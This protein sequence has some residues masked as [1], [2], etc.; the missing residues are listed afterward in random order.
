MS[1]RKKDYLN[2]I[3]NY[4]LED[5]LIEIRE[6]GNYIHFPF[7]KGADKYYPLGNS[8]L[9]TNFYTCP[10]S[11]FEYCRDM[12]GLT[13]DEIYDMWEK[14]RT[15]IRNRV[16]NRNINESVGNR[17]EQIINSISQYMLEDTPVE[18]NQHTEK[19]IIDY[20]F[21]EFGEYTNYRFEEVLPILLKRGYDMDMVNYLQKTYSIKDWNLIV[22]ISHRYY[23][24]LYYKVKEI[25]PPPYLSINESMDRKSNYLDKI[26][27]YMIEDTKWEITMER[28]NYE[29]YVQV[30]IIWPGGGDSIFGIEQMG[31]YWD[32]YYWDLSD[33][34]YLENNFGINDIVLIQELYNRYINELRHIIYKEMKDFEYSHKNSINE[35]TYIGDNKRFHDYII[36]NITNNTTLRDHHF[37]LFDCNISIHLNH[38][39][40]NP[41]FEWVPD[42][43]YTIMDRHY[44]L[45]FDMSTRI[46][47]WYAKYIIDLYLK[48]FNR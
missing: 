15:T 28:G 8:F 21:Y 9:P 7:F 22:G 46:W 48:D 47:V 24:L 3:L 14:Y 23:K 31:D 1:N 42:C 18:I 44:G 5:T 26:V 2:N 40:Y 33:Q 27:D 36:D 10:E 12:Y 39:R 19:I 45:D 13:V 38:S 17:E 35:S 32:I 43:F 30:S 29:N 4:I 34:E 37:Y 16:S 11:F 41:F 25:I 20:P 6:D